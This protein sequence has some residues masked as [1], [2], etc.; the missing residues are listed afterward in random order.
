MFVFK[1]PWLSFV[2]INVPQY[3]SRLTTSLC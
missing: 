1:P 2:N 3:R